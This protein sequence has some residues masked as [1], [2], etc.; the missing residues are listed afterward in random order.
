MIMIVS[1]A[2][3]TIDICTSAS[4]SRMRRE[5]SRMIVIWMSCGSCRSSAPTMAFTAS[6]TSTVFE[7]EILSTSSET[8]GVLAVSA[9]ISAAVRRFSAPSTTTA[10]SLMRTG[11][12]PRTVTGMSANALGSTMRPV[13]RTSFSVAPRSMRPAGTSWFSRWSA[14]A[15]CAGERP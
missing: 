2:P 8:A 15:S 12:P 7:P 4:D 13:T 10:T 1:A 9:K 11:V 6:A 14:A 5:S 3:S